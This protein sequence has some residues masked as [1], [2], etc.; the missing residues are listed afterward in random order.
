MVRRPA[1]NVAARIQAGGR[2]SNQ[3]IRYCVPRPPTAADDC[4]PSLSQPIL[5]GFDEP[6][7]DQEV[8]D[9]TLPSAPARPCGPADQSPD[10]S[11]KTVYLVDS[12]S[13]IYQVFHAMPEMT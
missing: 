8:N 1:R 6:L 3:R 2:K 10:L 12:H 13:L 7:A 11:G 4:M 5:N 9:Q